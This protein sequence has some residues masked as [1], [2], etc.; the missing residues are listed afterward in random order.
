MPDWILVAHLFEINDLYPKTF[1]VRA[2]ASRNL[3]SRSRVVT[4]GELMRRRRVKS[5][6]LRTCELWLLSTNTNGICDRGECTHEERPADRQS[7][8]IDSDAC[9]C[10]VRRMMLSA[11][12]YCKSWTRYQDRCRTENGTWTSRTRHLYAILQIYLWLI[13]LYQIMITLM[14]KVAIDFSQTLI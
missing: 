5:D 7:C 9:H 14:I 12:K 13:Q 2:S 6:S 10:H 4:G 11:R 3:P 1:K 8:I